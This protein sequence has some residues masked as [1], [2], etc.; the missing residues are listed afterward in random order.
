MA[1]LHNYGN[2]DIIKVEIYFKGEFMSKVFE[3]P[4]IFAVLLNP[5]QETKNEISTKD[6]I[7]N[8]SKY[9]LDFYDVLKKYYQDSCLRL[10]TCNPHRNTLD[11][12]EDIIMMFIAESN[13][14]TSYNLQLD[15]F[16]K[17]STSLIRALL[18]HLSSSK[19]YKYFCQQV[20]NRENIIAI[21]EYI[22]LYDDALSLYDDCNINSYNFSERQMDDV[23]TAFRSMSS[24]FKKIL[25]NNS[26]TNIPK[27]V[28]LFWSKYENGIIPRPINFNQ[29][30]APTSHD[31]DR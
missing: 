21:S 10:A 20:E 23:R 29:Y 22:A 31:D 5:S 30:H 17:S 25:Y 12:L 16:Y 6:N 26:H 27:A 19:D 4:S 18:P 9:T 13:I 8:L 3:N 11:E 15:S 7:Y 14:F 24:L 2:Y 28:E 1:Y